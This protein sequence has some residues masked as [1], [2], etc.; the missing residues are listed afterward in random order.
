MVFSKPCLLPF[1]VS[2]I[3]AKGNNFCDFLFASL[4]DEALPKGFTPRGK[5]LL[6]GQQILFFKSRPIMRWFT[7]HDHQPD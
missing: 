4:E 1:L 2:A 7:E 6:L 5:N 3:F